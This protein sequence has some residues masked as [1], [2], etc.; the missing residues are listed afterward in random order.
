MP[1]CTTINDLFS[2]LSDLKPA[3]RIQ[4]LVDLYACYAKVYSQ[5]ESLDE[6]ICWGDVLIADF[7]DIDK[8]LVDPEQVFTNVR[9]LKAIEDRY[10]YLSE[11]Q[12]QAISSFLS[13]FYKGQTGSAADF[14]VKGEIK[15]EFVKLWN[16]LLPLYRSFNELLDRK[17]QAYEGK[18]YRKVA[19]IPESV[20]SH[21]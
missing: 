6:F 2:G 18:I 3:S 19:G 7:N 17:G 13:H 21:L 15:G 1:E 5:A 20:S 10:E 4:L 12:R 8:Y 14:S 16:I 9:D 11:E